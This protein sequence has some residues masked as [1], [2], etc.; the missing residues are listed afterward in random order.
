MNTYHYTCELKGC[1]QKLLGCSHNN[2][3]D[4]NMDFFQSGNGR[5]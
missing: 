4:I 5:V 1:I 2:A 3:T